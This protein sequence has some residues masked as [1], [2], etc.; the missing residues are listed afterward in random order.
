MA[1]GRLERAVAGGLRACRG[2]AREGC[3]DISGVDDAVLQRPGEAT[4]PV[5][6]PP[7]RPCPARLAAEPSPVT[8]VVQGVFRSAAHPDDVAWGAA[9]LGHG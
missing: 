1:P 9:G 8:A 5:G 6:A 3:A 4:V 7:N 2:P